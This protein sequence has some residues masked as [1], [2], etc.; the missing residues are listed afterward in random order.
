VRIGRTPDDAE[1]LTGEPWFMTNSQIVSDTTED[2]LQQN[3]GL[4]R[5]WFID[6]VSRGELAVADELLSGDY[7]LPFPGLP[8]PVDREGHKG[9]VMLFRTGFPDWVETIEDVIAP[10]KRGRHTT[11]RDFSSSC[12]PHTD[13]RPER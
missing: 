7:R 11:P 6:V 13:R 10:W 4:Y 2:T 8:E 5:R 1:T 12:E 3:K 9:L